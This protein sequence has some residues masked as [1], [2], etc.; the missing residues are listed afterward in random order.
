MPILLAG[1]FYE[2]LESKQDAENISAQVQFRADHPIFAGHFPG[3]PVVPGVCQVQVLNELLN[4][5][6][7]AEF[8][9][10]SAATV[11]FLAPI[12]PVAQPIVNI[13]FTADKKEDGTL[14]VNGQFTGSD[15]IFFKFKGIFSQQ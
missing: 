1:T 5:A 4:A 13:H 15:K 9:L 10:Q 7:G 2:T 3:M 6:L 11:K 14:A 12:D 8:L